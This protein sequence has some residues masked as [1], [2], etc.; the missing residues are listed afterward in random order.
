M[1]LT[2]LFE[3]DD[4]LV[5]NKPAGLLV[6]ISEHGFPS[7][8]KWALDYQQTKKKKPFVGIVHRLDRPVSGALLLAKKPSIL[9]LLNEQFREKTVEKTY[10]AIAENEPPKTRGCL[11]H[12]LLKDL[13]NKRAEVSLKKVKGSAECVLHYELRQQNTRGFLIEVHPKTGKFHQIRAQLAAVGCPI[14]GDERYGARQLY[15]PDSIALHA[16]RLKFSSPVTNEGLEISAP[17]PA[18][19]LWQSFEV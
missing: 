1:T 6:E 18:D 16:H 17:P 4:F 15:R 2:I 11:T 7:V 3:T 9:K 10:L 5:V 14:I 19:E 12:W 8:E 13:K